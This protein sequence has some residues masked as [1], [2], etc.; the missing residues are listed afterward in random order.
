MNSRGEAVRH[1]ELSWMG[2]LTFVQPEQTMRRKR[3]PPAGVDRGQVGWI[4]GRT[5]THRLSGRRDRFDPSWHL[6]LLRYR[7][8]IC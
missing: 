7:F 2:L 4:S 8:G 1:R 6:R 3:I 5:V